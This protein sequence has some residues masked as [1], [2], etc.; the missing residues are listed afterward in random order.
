MFKFFKSLNLKSKKSYSLFFIRA[1]KGGFHTYSHGAKF[2]FPRSQLKYALNNA[3]FKRAKKVDANK[4]LQLILKLMR[5]KKKC[6]FVPP[7]KI[8]YRMTQVSV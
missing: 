1:I 2:F 5:K 6:L 3:F 4:D 8:S 7:V